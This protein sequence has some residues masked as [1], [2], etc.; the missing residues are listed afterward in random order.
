VKL[1]PAVFVLVTGALATGCGPYD[2]FPP[3]R[4]ARSVFNG[5]DGWDT[6]SVQPYQE[7]MPPVPEGTVPFGGT[8]GFA[9]AKARFDTLAPQVRSADATTAWR[10][11][12]YPCH[13]PNGDGRII[14]GESFSPAPPDL[15]SER[16]QSL[17][18][19]QI[20]AQVRTG[21]ANMI[22][23]SDTLTPVE[24]LLVIAR[25]RTLPERPS[26]PFFTPKDTRPLE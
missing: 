4:L 21:S 14:V 15:R 16:S 13:G 12:C 8:E 11:Y 19:E 7:P 24:T 25:L 17:T 20:Y 1:D 3:E 26:E 23:L 10:R 22:P 5:W 2:W 9:E 6:V 18:D